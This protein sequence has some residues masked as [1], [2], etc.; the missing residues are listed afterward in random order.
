MSDKATYDGVIEWQRGGD[1][2]RS[3]RDWFATHT[4]MEAMTETESRLA[5]KA[6]TETAWQKGYDG[7]ESQSGNDLGKNI[8]F[9][10]RQYFAT[11][12]T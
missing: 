12:E 1:G 6:T 10:K 11:E 2:T 9:P 8:D 3:L 4:T 7:A 5:T